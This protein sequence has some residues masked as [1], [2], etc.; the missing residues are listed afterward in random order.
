MFAQIGLITSGIAGW[1]LVLHYATG[2]STGG[3][4]FVLNMPFYLLAIM[5]L[6]WPFT[7]KTIS[8]VTLLSLLVEAETHLIRLETVD[9]L[10]GAILGGVLMGFGLLGVFRHRASVGG[11]TILAVWLQDLTGMRAGVTLFVFDL[12]VFAAALAVAPWPLVG[13]SLVGAVVLNLF[14]AINHRT[15]RYIAH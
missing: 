12:T 4:F 10:F 15:D 9:P 7:L 6:G 13:Y 8:A 3:F 11:I 5:R 14:L 1:S 2:W